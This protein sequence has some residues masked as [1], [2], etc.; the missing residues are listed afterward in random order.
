LILTRQ[1]DIFDY[2]HEALAHG[3][4]SL[5][6]MNAGIAVDFKKSYPDMFREYQKRCNSGELRPGDIFFYE[7]R[8]QPHV[9]NLVT[10]DNLF[11]AKSE[12][13]ESALEK[14][15]VFA[16]EREIRDIAMPNIGEGLGNLKKGR[17]MELL[18][19]LFGSS[20][21][22]VTVYSRT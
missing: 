2:E 22:N 21:I 7:S 12:Y 5:G 1:G 17:L 3:V 10:Q 6:M 9:F 19:P 14:M 15:L 16:R 4:N 20:D 11:G 13:V 18:R 8:V